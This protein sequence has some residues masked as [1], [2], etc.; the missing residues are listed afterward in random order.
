MYLSTNVKIKISKYLGRMQSLQKKRGG[1]KESGS[2]TAAA[3]ARRND[4]RGHL[5]Q[6]TNARSG[7]PQ[8]MKLLL[9][10]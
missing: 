10:V 4:I 9:D 6:S 2:G 3:L 5:V 8:K 1:K 7:T